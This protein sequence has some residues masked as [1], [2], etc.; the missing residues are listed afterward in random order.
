VDQPCLPVT[1]LRRVGLGS[2]PLR[3]IGKIEEHGRPE[4]SVARMRPES[5]LRHLAHPFFLDVRRLRAAAFAPSFPS[6]VRVFFGRREIVFFR[7]A[8]LA[9]F[10]MFLRAAA[11]C[12]VVAIADLLSRDVPDH[13]LTGGHRLREA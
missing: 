3:E 4:E 1:V 8:A 11:F 2:K 5:F 7:L 12:F 6:A 13:R 10:L 9:A